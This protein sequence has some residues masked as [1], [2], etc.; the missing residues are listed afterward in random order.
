MAT[1]CLDAPVEAFRRLE[2]D[3]IHLH[4]VLQP[5]QKRPTAA[6][7][8]EQLGRSLKSFYWDR[9]HEVLR[10]PLHLNYATYLIADGAYKIGAAG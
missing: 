8:S 2:Y 5:G 9:V 7:V 6:V 3:Y 1:A 4:Y 10:H